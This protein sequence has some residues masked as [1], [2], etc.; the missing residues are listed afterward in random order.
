MEKELIPV[1]QDINKKLKKFYS[2]KKR[3]KYEELIKEIIEAYTALDIPEERIDI[4]D[5]LVS[6]GKELIKDVNMKDNKK[7]EFYLG[8]CRA[9]IFDFNDNVK[10]LAT[11]L[12]LFLLTA[13]LFFVLSPQNFSFVLPIVFFLP[14]FMGFRGIRNRQFNGLFIGLSIVPMA[15]LVSIVW[16]RNAI[17]TISTGTFGDFINGL[18]QSYNVSFEFSRNLA[19][20]FIFMSVVM[21]VSS[22]SFLIYGIKYRKM[23]I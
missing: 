5:S 13:A 6:R 21:M 2:D 10:P 19:I 9:A 14:V 3:T 23:F 20:V 11:I 15:I 7:V 12:K 16:I 1:L 17:L 8:Y 18:A 4:Y 22:I